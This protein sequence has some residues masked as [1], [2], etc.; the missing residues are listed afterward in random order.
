MAESRLDL[1][2][3][4]G[5]EPVAVGSAELLKWHHRADLVVE[6]TG[7]P[8]VASGITGFMANGGKGLFF[9]VCP[10]DAKINVSPFEVFRRQL[11]LAGSHSLNHSIQRSLEIID[12]LGRDIER[13]V[14]HSL[15]QKEISNILSS[16]PPE[17]S[18][19]IQ[20]M[21]N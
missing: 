13:A 20:W 12:G 2:S 8:A 10:S 3:S 9:G 5:F 17:D 6:A 1:A 16:K 4:F 15:P 21:V 14:S 7:V 18:L 11:T 19:K